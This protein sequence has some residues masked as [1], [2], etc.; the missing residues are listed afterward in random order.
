MNSVDI[1]GMQTGK[2]DPSWMDLDVDMDA[3]LSFEEIVPGKCWIS[4]TRQITEA[5]VFAFAE[6][7]GDRNPIH[8]D[9]EFASTTP[10]RK[11]IAHGLLGLSWVAGLGFEAPTVQT[12]ALLSIRNW[13]FHR[14]IYFG[15]VVHVRTTVLEKQPDARRNGRVVWRMEL[16]NQH[17]VTV[18]SGILESLVRLSQRVPKPHLAGE[19]SIGVVR[20]HIVPDK[21]TGK[22]SS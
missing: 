16:I 21:G 14:P 7:T 20:K 22:S 19:H 11:R 15:D 17:Q 18:Q 5:D 12:V 10:Y 6:L 9:E 4:S 1:A 8:L 2:P 13:E 3:A